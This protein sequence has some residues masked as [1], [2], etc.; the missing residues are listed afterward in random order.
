MSFPC[1]PASRRKHA[2]YARVANRELRGVERV[3]AVQAHERDLARADEEQV[4]LL[5]LVRLLATEREIA[6][7]LHRALEHHDRR[8]HELEPARHEHVDR[9]ARDRELEERAIAGERVRATARELSRTLLV[10]EAEVVHQ[11]DVILRLE[12]ELARRADLADLDVVLFAL[13]DRDLGPRD[14]RHAEHELVEFLL[15]LGEG[16]LELLDVR[17]DR[18]AFFDQLRAVFLRSLRD[19]RGDLVLAL[20]R[21]LELRDDLATRA[22]RLEQVVEVRNRGACW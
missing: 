19:R 16:G 11:I 21:A 18:L 10:H 9:E 2:E 22:V 15:R 4:V 1:A 14:A 12:L 3:V 13:A 20:S 6:R 17:L 5:H 7:P 8:D